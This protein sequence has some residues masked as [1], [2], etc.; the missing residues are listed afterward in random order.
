MLLEE[1]VEKKAVELVNKFYC[2]TFVKAWHVPAKWVMRAA[3]DHAITCVEE[4]IE[5][6]NKPFAEA[7]SE[8]TDFLH[9]LKAKLKKML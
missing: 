6:Q 5:F 2:E 8:D 7:L 9:A 1:Q 3:V 4:I